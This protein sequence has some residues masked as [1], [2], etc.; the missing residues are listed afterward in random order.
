MTA[1]LYR[2]SNGVRVIVDEVPHT[3]AAS[4]GMYFTVGSRHETK[5]NNGVAHFL[6]HMLFRG[7][8]KRTDEQID[9]EAQ[10]MGASFNAYT[11]HEGTL[12]HITGMAADT[13]RMID[14]LGDMVCNATLPADN[15]EKERGAVISEILDAKGN[16][17]SSAD[18]A[19]F[20]AAYPDHPLGAS[21]LG[22]EKNIR[23][24]SR[25]TLKRFKDRHYNTGNLIVSVA[26]NVKAED[27][28]KDLEPALAGLPIGLA[29]AFR[30]AS[31]VGDSIHDSEKSDQSYVTLQFESYPLDHP[32][33][34]PAAIAGDILGGRQASRLFQEV[35]NKRGLAYAVN[36]IN[37]SRIDTGLLQIATSGSRKNMKKALSVICDVL[38]KAAKEGFTEEEIAMSKAS[39]RTFFAI[40]GDSMEE[41]MSAAAKE[42][43]HY[44]C[45]R[46]PEQRMQ[47]LDEK[48][49]PESLRETV[50]EI[51]SR[52][53]SIVTAGPG[54]WIMKPDEIAR[55]LSL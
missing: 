52:T 3:Q 30:K 47:E 29:S 53:P 6:E 34:L 23:K 8:K 16:G 35:R 33:S 21:V 51:F 20:N 7:T 40:A 10:M 28:L 27:V 41:R 46:T 36:T 25:A 19:A 5:K 11:T 31:Y 15:F 49:T 4:V 14:I 2:L 44:G 37:V 38:R 12:Y 1:E 54:G 17:D 24:M 45:L 32:R 48:V 43:H 9:R 18:E 39:I 50:R 22:P 42:L 13:P 26:G 55:R